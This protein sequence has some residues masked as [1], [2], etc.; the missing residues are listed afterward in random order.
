MNVIVDLYD[1]TTALLVAAREGHII[2]ALL[3][4]QVNMNGKY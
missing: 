3:G 1:G 4:Y 2:E